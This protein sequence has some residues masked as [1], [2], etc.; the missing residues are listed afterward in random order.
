[1]FI[2]N[3]AGF[4]PSTPGM[5]AKFPSIFLNFLIPNI[6]QLVGGGKTGKGPFSHEET[7]PRHAKI[8]NSD[9]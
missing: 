7:P 3:G 6:L 4:L 9:G 1:M 8:K 2:T 5:D